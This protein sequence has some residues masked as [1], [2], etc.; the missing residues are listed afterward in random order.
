MGSY[1]VG[2]DY[3]IGLN[4]TE[5]HTD[6][7]YW[8]VAVCRLGLPLSFSRKTM[9]SVTRDLTEGFR[10]ID[11]AKRLLT[12]TDDILSIN[13]SS[14]KKSVTSSMSLLLAHSATN[15]LIEVLPG[16]HVFG[17]IVSNDSDY[18]SL[19]AR[20]ESGE[21]C[22][23]FSD[24][25][26]FVGRIFSVRKA[27]K[28]QAG[29]GTKTVNYTV[30]CTGFSELETSMYYDHGVASHDALAKDIVN[31]F[32]RLG[33]SYAELFQTSTEN[34]VEQGNVN[35]L[36]PVFIDL[37]LGR[38]PSKLGKITVEVEDG[39]TVDAMPSVN[40]APFAY[41]IPVQ[42]GQLL[43]RKHG[44]KADNVMSYADILELLIGTQEYGFQH[45]FT[46]DETQDTSTDTFVESDK[47]N[48]H[49]FIPAL[50]VNV[51]GRRVTNKPML[52]TFLPN[53]PEFTNMPLWQVLKRYLNPTINEMYSTLR[54]NPEGNVM[55]TI[56]VRQI[57]FTTEAY[58]PDA[59][60]STRSSN[61][62]DTNAS[63]TK[64]LSLPRW[65]I[66]A[67]MVNQVDVGR[68]D[69]TNFNFVH[70][71]GQSSL[72]TDGNNPIQNQIAEN[73]PIIDSLS[74]CRSGLKPYS[75][76]VE[77]WVDQQVGKA[78]GTWMRLVADFVM[79]SHLTL[80]GTLTCLGI[81]SPIAVGD[82]ISFDGVVYM[83]ESVSHTAGM[84]GGNKSWTT[85]L[86]LTN[87]MR[88][89]GT[90]DSIDVDDPQ[91]IYPGLLRTDN[92]RFDPGLSEE[93]RKTTGGDNERQLSP[94]KPKRTA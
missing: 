77:T 56:V 69:A 4:A 59:K 73:P 51:P 91:P 55:P 72:L 19:L 71:Y 68:S 62:S 58:T 64:F 79:G 85:S 9:T 48:H 80:N 10:P 89:S 22:N 86:S 21:P 15:Y 36:I 32:T 84:F 78:P 61:V 41:L 26:K 54:V 18:R 43:G 13:V 92:T 8:V 47:D 87:G 50:K 60:V 3:G 81:Q 67:A 65:K 42:V 5:V 14:S 90:S 38:G 53:M 16:D 35:K 75:T 12:I 57:P 33:I 27:V 6:G 52:G 66:P 49:V 20:L 70:I 76:T 7:P 63:Y 37:I 74:V 34:G 46:H 24:G 29:I 28:V 39:K 94:L 45:D 17:W 31:W 30:Q 93:Q 83:I 23:K 25:L 40:E 82:C 11:S 1:N 2:Q 88:E 44:S